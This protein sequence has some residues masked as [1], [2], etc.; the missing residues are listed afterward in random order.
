MRNPAGPDYLHVHEPFSFHVHEPF[1]NVMIS[2]VTI[3]KL[4]DSAAVQIH[5]SFSFVKSRS[6]AVQH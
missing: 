4:N 1:S 6:A 2:N 3:T 5:E